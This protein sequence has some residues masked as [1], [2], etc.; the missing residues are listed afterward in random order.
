MKNEEKEQ[1]VLYRI[2]RAKE[3]LN[4]I[5]I[6]IENKFTSTAIN[7]IYYACFYAVSALLLNNDIK[8]QTHSGIRQM[9]GLHFIKSGI[10]QKDLGKFYSDIFDMRHTSDYDDFIRF[11]EKEVEDAKDFA[12]KLIT[13]IEE[14]IYQ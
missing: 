14:L 9:F 6:L 4:E 11:S 7:R 5:N 10:I 3:T 8:T 13:N 12:E 1:L 2:E